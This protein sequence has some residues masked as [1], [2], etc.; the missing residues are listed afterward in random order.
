L[1]LAANGYHPILDY[2]RALSP[3]GN[4]VALGGSMGQI[5]QGILLGALVSRS[6]G[7]KMGFMGIA[8]INDKD[9]IIMGELLKAGQVV[10]IIERCY[11]LSEAAEAVRY[12]AEGHARG[13]V[14]ITLENNKA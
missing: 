2:R 10:P 6:G 4:Y 13:K 3:R 8:K 1:I 11:P 7:K 12:L 14:V 9:L 5:I